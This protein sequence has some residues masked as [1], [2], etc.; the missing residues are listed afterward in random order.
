MSAVEEEREITEAEFDELKKKIKT[1]TRPVI[2]TRHTFE[3]YGQVFEID[4]YPSWKCTAIMETE[5]DSDK[6]IVKMPPFIKIIKEVTGAPG[7]SNAAMSKS[8]PKESD[9]E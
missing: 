8:F 5:L 6:K 2:K 4:V 1:G 3:Y 9:E 7:Y